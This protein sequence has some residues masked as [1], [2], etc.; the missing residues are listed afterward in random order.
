MYIYLYSVVCTNTPFIV[1]CLPY[2]PEIVKIGEFSQ[3]CTRSQKYVLV[4]CMTW[5][6][7]DPWSYNLAYSYTKCKG[8]SVSALCIA[9]QSRYDKYHTYK[10]LRETPKEPHPHIVRNLCTI[11]TVLSTFTKVR[12][13]SYILQ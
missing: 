7:E 8:F 5:F 3:Y 11:R 4:F 10:L 2:R 13:S 6:Y 9:Y 12:Y 1:R